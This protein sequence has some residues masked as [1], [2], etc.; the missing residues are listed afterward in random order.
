MIQKPFKGISQQLEKKT[1]SHRIAGCLRGGEKGGKP[2]KMAH[3]PKNRR[4]CGGGAHTVSTRWNIKQDSQTAWG[5]SRYRCGAFCVASS[6]CV[7]VSS[8]SPALSPS[9]SASLFC[10]CAHNC[11]ERLDF[12]VVIPHSHWTTPPPRRPRRRRRRRRCG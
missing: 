5:R 8:L 10:V 12:A 7:C 11:R 6:L 9:L 1:R 2:A 3:G 4:S